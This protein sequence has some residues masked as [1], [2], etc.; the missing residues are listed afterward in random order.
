M[1]FSKR[2]AGASLLSIAVAVPT[3]DL[4]PIPGVKIRE[5]EG[6]TADIIPNSWIIHYK[7]GIPTVEIAQHRSLIQSKL[8]K[9]PEAVFTVPGFN[10]VHVKTDSHGLAKIA[11]SST[12]C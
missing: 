7:T 1:R 9:A 6:S 12:V 11:V 3:P 4:A 10:A 2:L 5:I 8:G